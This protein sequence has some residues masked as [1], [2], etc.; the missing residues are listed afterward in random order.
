M[1]IGRSEQEL[2]VLSDDGAGMEMARGVG[3]N[4]RTVCPRVPPEHEQG[5]VFI[6]ETEW[7]AVG[8]AAWEPCG[9]VGK[10]LKISDK[11]KDDAAEDVESLW[12]SLTLWILGEAWL[13]G[14]SLKR[15]WRPAAALGVPA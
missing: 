1:D 4:A 11:F 15:T 14:K 8:G 3:H 9:G 2:D 13:S 7:V 5:T 12:G 6:R 10:C